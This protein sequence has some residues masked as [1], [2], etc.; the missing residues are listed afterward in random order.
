MPKLGPGGLENRDSC[1]DGDWKS[2]SNDI[3]YIAGMT[4]ER[5]WIDAFVWR[6]NA[7]GDRTGPFGAAAGSLRFGRSGD[8]TGYIVLLG[9]ETRF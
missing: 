4:P 9:S 8:I 5:W 7:L 3:S 1:A 2:S 6:I